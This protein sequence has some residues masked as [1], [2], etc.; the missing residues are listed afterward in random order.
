MIQETVDR[1]RCVCPPERISVITGNAHVEEVARQLPELSPEQIIVEPSPR[2][3]G[4]AIGLSA[5][6]VHRRDPEAIVGSFAADHVV[7][8]PEFFEQAVQ[9]AIELAERGYLVTV[10]I[11]PSYAE[12]GYGYICAGDEIG[13]CEGVT[14][15]SVGSFK[16]KPDLATA[17]EYVSSGRYLWNSSMF[18]WQA[19]TLMEEMHSLLPDLAKS[20]EAIAADWDTDRR[21]ATFHEIWPG[22]ADIS[23]DHGILERSGKVA[24]VPGAFGW[25]DLGDWHGLGRILATDERE[26]IALASNVLI[27]DSHGTV[28]VGGDRMVVVLGLDNVVVVDTD[29]AV[30][31][32]DRAHA[33]SVKDVVSQLRL[34]GSTGLI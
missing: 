5:A 16:E 34:R 7:S 12:I 20:L 31:V 25:T 10:G 8:R 28:I 18:V 11:K 1:L 17:E 4:P 19:K 2:G 3:S 9:A 13:V 15:Y 30:L 23:I 32:C 14:V 6:I 21:E 24:V 29:D 26:N 22:V 27:Q 33:Q